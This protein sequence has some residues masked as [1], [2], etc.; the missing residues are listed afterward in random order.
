MKKIIICF[1]M[2]CISVSVSVA[3]NLDPTVEVTRGYKVELAEVHKPYMDMAVPDSVQKFDLDFEY[4]VTDSP[5]RGSYEFNPYVMDLKPQ[6][7]G[8]TP[9]VLYLNAG[10]GY[11]VNPVFDIVYSPVLDGKFSV[12]LFGHHESYVGDYRAPHIGGVQAGGGYKNGYDLL[13]GASADFGYDWEKAEMGLGVSYYGVAVKDNLHKDDFNALDARFSVKSKS[14]WSQS[15]FY[16]IAVDYRFGANSEVMEHV[17]GLNAKFGPVIRSRHKVFLGLGGSF[18]KYDKA[19]QTAYGSAYILP[20][21]K[22]VTNWFKADLG[23]RVSY[24]YSNNEVFARKNQYIYPEVHVDCNIKDAMRLYLNVTGGEELNTYSSLLDRNHHFHMKYQLRDNALLGSS[25]V[26]VRPEFGIEGKITNF[27]S[28]DFKTGYSLTAA[29][30]VSALVYMDGAYAPALGYADMQTWYAGLDW[31]LSLKSFRFYGGLK[32]THLMS[33]QQEPENVYFV[34]PSEWTMNASA[35]Y[36]WNKRL[37]VGV[38]CVAASSG[39]TYDAAV[40]VPYYV[41]L[42]AFAEYVVN[43]K[44]SVW[45]RGGNLLDMEIQKNPLYAEKGINFTAGFCL[46]LQ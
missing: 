17:V 34:R 29:S 16:N 13:S 20:H 1:A 15:F 24:V 19:L 32:Y 26:R 31:N 10:A 43:K 6:T 46:N 37:F 33:M 25:L 12:G 40:Y 7:A 2:L 36:N 28:Y 39:K 14:L 38:D 4:S 44:F 18:V 21:Y 41:D 35:V 22:Y 9:T 5:Y 11:T 30:P 27:F 42:G 45:L 23:A 3:Q 8:E